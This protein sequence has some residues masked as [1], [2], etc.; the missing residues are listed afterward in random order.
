[1]EDTTPKQ[2][3][4][5]AKTPDT[6]VTPEAVEEPQITTTE[7]K[8]DSYSMPDDADLLDPK[9]AKEVIEKT[10]DSRL[11]EMRGS[12][13]GQRINQEVKD[14]LEQNPE[15][16][17]YADKINKWVNHP[18]RI[19]FIKNGFPV[20]SVVLE[21]IAPHLQQ[22]GAEKARAADQKAR[23]SE[24]SGTTTAPQV[25]STTTDFKAMSNKDIE[26]MAERVKSGRM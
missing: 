1:M 7:G 5:P 15:Y 11:S 22:I 17:P 26:N 20:K 16:K 8:K 18:N 12:M 10:I 3:S 4:P 13:E 23:E 19:Q 21:A 25:A 2:E 24:G 6:V 9:Q 14:I